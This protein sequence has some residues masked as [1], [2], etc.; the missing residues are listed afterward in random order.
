MLV[1]LFARWEDEVATEK[2]LTGHV[3]GLGVRGKLIRH[4]VLIAGVKG[5]PVLICIY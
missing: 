5:S 2:S 1:I 3:V 4:A